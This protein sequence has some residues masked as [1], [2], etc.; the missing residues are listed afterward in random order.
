MFQQH[1]I[2]LNWPHAAFPEVFGV[3][4]IYYVSDPTVLNM[5]RTEIQKFLSEE[6]VIHV[7]REDIFQNVMDHYSSDCELQH[8]RVKVVFHGEEI[9]EDF[10]GLTRG[11]F[12]TFFA[13]AMQQMFKGNL[14]KVPDMDHRFIFRDY[15]TTLGRIISHCF[16]L[17]GYFPTTFARAA[18]TFMWTGVVSYDT[19]LHSF[20]NT[21]SEEER[22][23]I[24]ACLR[25]LSKI[26]DPSVCLKAIRILSVYS[27][28][29][30]VT[31]SNFRQTI[32]EVARLNVVILPLWA[33]TC[34]RMGMRCYPLLWDGISENG[35]AAFYEKLAPTVEKALEKVKY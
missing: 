27:C 8:H 7:D 23:V 2:K 3:S 10:E 4:I 35:L 26:D 9:A 19:C 16:V 18:I 21:L 29:I 24:Q 33:L 32:I 20:L 31:R 6:K 12:T 22:L 30:R 34:I 14:E 5:R 1:L 17:T 25:D 13:K 15:M 28:R 11:M